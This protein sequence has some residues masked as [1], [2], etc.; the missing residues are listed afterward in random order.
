MSK[1]A[2]GQQSGRVQEQAKQEGQLCRYGVK[3]GDLASTRHKPPGVADGSW[4]CART[5]FR[6]RMLRTHRGTGAAAHRGGRAPGGRAGG[7]EQRR[8]ARGR[9]GAGGRAGADRRH[10]RKKGGGPVA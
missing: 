3:G 9:T 7:R 6:R 5:P 4:W 1:T 8:R 2:G 10:K